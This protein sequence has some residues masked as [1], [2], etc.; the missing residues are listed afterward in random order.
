VSTTVVHSQRKAAA[1]DDLNTDKPSADRS[2]FKIGNNPA[3]D[4]VR[5]S[6]SRGL[7]NRNRTARRCARPAMPNRNRRVGY[8]AVETSAPAPRARRF[9]PPTHARSLVEDGGGND[10][11]NR[12]RPFQRGG[13]QGTA[14]LAWV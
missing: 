8:P 5:R 12:T 9:H 4:R 11:E 6:K 2:A 10:D 3:D 14:A 13:G 1:H 7:S